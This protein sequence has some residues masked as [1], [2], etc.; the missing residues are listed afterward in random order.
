MTS[1]IDLLLTGASGN[2]GI[3]V[4]KKVVSRSDSFNLRIFT[5]GSKK[6]R[7]LFKPYKKEVE[8]VWGDILDYEAVKKA[9]DGQ[10]IIIHM[11]GLIPPAC[12]KD[13]EYTYKVNVKGTKNILTAGN[14]SEKAPKIIYTSS[15][16]VYGDRLDDP[17]IS[18]EDT[19]NPNDIY[20]VTKLKAEQLIRESNLNYL[21]FRLSYCASIRTLKFNPILFLMPLETNIEIIHTKDVALAIV[22][23]IK[24]DKIWDKT[25][26]LAGGKDCRIKYGDHINDLFEIIG[27]GKDLLP[28]DAFADQ[29]FNCGYYK[30]NSVHEKLKYQR[31]DLED[32]Y[33]EVKSWIGFKRYLVPLVKW[34]VK[35]YLLRKLRK[36]SFLRKAER[37]KDFKK[38]KHII[39]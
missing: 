35:K 15:I 33:K 12:Y 2:V 31:H 6:N 14:D 28:E 36:A 39:E 1:K 5:R 23:A 17:L 9:V 24:F 30:A 8:I 10:D 26:N 16:V 27:L 3:D 38:Y 29:G 22:N 32:F 21:I 19:P 13:D 37:R 4:F 11:A 34:F 25:I 7:K 18:I 20:G